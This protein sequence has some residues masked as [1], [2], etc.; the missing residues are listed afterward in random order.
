MLN[1]NQSNSTEY[2]KV[3]KTNIVNNGISHD[4]IDFSSV[5]Y[6]GKTIIVL[7]GNNT[8]NA[9]NKI[10]TEVSNHSTDEHS[11]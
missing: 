6:N 9:F 2:F 7:S 3:V 8:K 5:N 10:S 4:E 11:A 1:D